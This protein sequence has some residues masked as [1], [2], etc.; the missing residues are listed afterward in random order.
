MGGLKTT[1]RR[2]VYRISYAVVHKVKK[3]VNKNLQTI[4]ESP[5]MELYK[6]QETRFFILGKL[7]IVHD[8]IQCLIKC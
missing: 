6:I 2:V 1:P 5:Q 4:L 3:I 8:Y 7:P